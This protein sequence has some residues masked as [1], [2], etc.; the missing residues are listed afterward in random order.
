MGRKQFV[1][2]GQTLGRQFGQL[3]SAI[4]QRIGG[5]HSGAAAV[6]D[7]RQARAGGSR[8]LGQ[9]LGQVEELADGID[10][11]HSHPPEGGVEHFIAS[12]ERARVRG[13]RLGR[14][15]RTTDFDDDDRFR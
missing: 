14:R 9:K 5:Q 2:L 11:Q 1:Q 15:L 8:L 7:N 13:R 4:N 3:A 6:R 10:A 12:R